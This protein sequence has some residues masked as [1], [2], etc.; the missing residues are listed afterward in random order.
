LKLISNLHASSFSLKGRVALVTGGATGIG[1]HIA[2]AFAEAGANVAI[3][4]NT[5]KDT[6]NEAIGMLEKEYG[7]RA[8]MVYMPAT[9][10]ERV[11]EGVQEVVVTFGRLDVVSVH[12]SP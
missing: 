3:G 7:V 6:A 11:E 4:F 1:W 10:P 8:M 9:D 5:S 2:R 12:R